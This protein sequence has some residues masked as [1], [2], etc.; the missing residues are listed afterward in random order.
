[1]DSFDNF[2]ACGSGF[3]HGFQPWDAFQAPCVDLGLPE[4]SP[5]IE[6][7][8]QA[9]ALPAVV[10][11]YAFNPA[12]PNAAVGYAMNEIARILAGESTLSNAE[13]FRLLSNDLCRDD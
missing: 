12:A 10:D 4:P 1:M 3:D 11:A 5:W 6:D 8:P 2:S 9:Y 13:Q 7:D